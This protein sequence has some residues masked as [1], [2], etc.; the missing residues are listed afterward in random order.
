MRIFSRISLLQKVILSVVLLLFLALAIQVVFVSLQI[1]SIYLNTQKNNIA[2]FVQKQALQH[3]RPTD[4]HANPPSLKEAQFEQF[5]EEITT[6]EIVRVKIYNTEGV[7]LYSDEKSLIGQK[8]FQ[9]E[10][11]ELAEILDGTVVAEIADLNKEENVFEKQYGKLLEIY[12]PIYFGDS[13]VEGI[14]ESYYR[15]DILDQEI[16]KSQLYSVIELFAVFAILSVVLFGI[17]KNA[18]RQLVEQKKQLEIDVAKEKEYSK[19]KA[20]FISLASHQLRTPAASVHWSLELI[21]D[22][23]ATLTKNQK[24]AV[25]SSYENIETLISIVNRMLTV[26]KIKPDY[27]TFEPSP[28]RFDRFL[29]EVLKQKSKAL[30]NKQLDL[31]IKQQETSYMITIQKEAL[32]IILNSL[33]DNAIVYSKPGATITITLS[34]PT[35]SKLRFDIKDTGIGIPLNEH[36]KVFQEFFRAKNSIEQKNAASGLSLYIVKK[37]IDGYGEKISFISSPSGTTFSF[38]LS[39]TP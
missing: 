14:V 24:A 20:E 38:T 1:Q 2:Q 16:V 12:T 18:S 31:K 8:L 15:L 6:D 11:D 35:S 27:F 30:T 17:L 13:R 39:T 34:K 32:S 29:G 10:E 9:G 37:I 36:K 22:E 5:T 25:E 26:A 28:Y 21:K 33:I 19:L 7:V 3:L 4:F 23:M